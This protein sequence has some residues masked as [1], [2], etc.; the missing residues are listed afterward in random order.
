MYIID[1]WSDYRMRFSTPLTLDMMYLP[2]SICI[3]D[4]IMLDAMIKEGFPKKILHITGNP[5]F[6]TFQNRTSAGTGN[7]IVFASQPFSETYDDDDD[8]GRLSEITIF[9]DYARVLEECGNTMPVYIALHPR[10]KKKHKFDKIIANSKLN[11]SITQEKTIDIARGAR[12][13]VGIRTML[14][15]EVA[16]LGKAVIS[17]QPGITSKD[18]VLVSNHLGVSTPAYSYQDLV[19]K[20]K[21]VLATESLP[22]NLEAAR[23]KYI[24]NN[25]TEKVIV[26]ICNLTSTSKNP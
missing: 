14:L 10:E 6:D 5:F 9:S 23:K 22:K 2:D 15:F 4:E 21:E 8:H 18:D 12:L 17:Y 13:I 3:I 16:M 1:Y 7:Y 25:S 20:I 26:E 11:I 19:V 24:Y